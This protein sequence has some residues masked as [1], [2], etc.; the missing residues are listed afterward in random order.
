ME[1]DRS[2]AAV[3]PLTVDT[4]YCWNYKTM[5]DCQAKTE[6]LLCVSTGKVFII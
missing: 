1:T 2:G 6:I 5:E 4:D 3:W